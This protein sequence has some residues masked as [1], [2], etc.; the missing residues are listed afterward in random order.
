MTTI[1]PD[2]I[3]ATG[4]ADLWCTYAAVRTLAWLGRIRP[5]PH[6]DQTA[7]LIRNRRN[8]DGGY[9]WSRGMTS[10]AWATF[11]CMSTL[12]DLAESDDDTESTLRW[13]SSVWSGEAFAMMPGQAPEVWA[14]HFATRT[15]VELCGADVPDRTALL[16]WLGALQTESGGLAWSP[17]HATTGHAD[18]RA[19]YYAIASWRAL[20][21]R[22]VT[23][24]PWDVPGLVRWLQQRQTTSGGFVFSEADTVPCMWATYRTVGSLVQLGARPLRNPT[25]WI[26]AQRDGS[27]AFVRWPDHPVA[28]VWASFSAVGT[29]R[30]LGEDLTGI[31]DATWDRLDTMACD[32]GGF[33]YREPDLAADALTV[34]AAAL[35]EDQD[36]SR[37][38]TLVGWLETCMLPNEDGIMYMPGRGAEVRCTSWAL[39]A[40]AFADDPGRLRAIGTWLAGLQN[41]DGGVGYWKGRGS[42]LV[43]TASA[44]EI[45]RTTHQTD[46]LDLQGLIAFTQACRGAEAGEYGNVPGGAPTARSALHAVRVFDAARGTSDVRAVDVLERHRVPGGGWA[47][48]G[49]RMPDLLTTYEAVVTADRFGI[50]V[51]RGHLRRFLDRT[52]S[53]AEAA[54]SPLAPP[55]SDPLAIGLHRLLR[56]RL[57]R[58]SF[59]LPPVS[60]S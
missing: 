42:D 51:D 56:R 58:D 35:D 57:A 15:T 1:V 33:T 7:A 41:P 28:D 17:G 46:A 38:G 60:L 55:G 6:L 8:A 24:P 19:C 54:W 53:G 29:L 18:A 48:T 39:H 30:E 50:E 44:V 32:G 31:A 43:S 26:L 13:L 11:Y 12:M 36:T 40:G 3:P 37:R 23:E 25:S 2:G 16:R 9:A 22:E 52:A 5:T 27:G 34:A 21:S 47:N 59:I 49:R 14:T 20:A 45:M 4:E 10:D